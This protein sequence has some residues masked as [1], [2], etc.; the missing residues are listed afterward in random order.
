[1]TLKYFCQRSFNQGISDSYTAV[2]KT[3]S[4][5]ELSYKMPQKDDNAHSVH[6]NAS[7]RSKLAVIKKFIQ[8]PKGFYFNK[9][10]GSAYGEGYAFHQAEVSR[11]PRLVEWILKNDYLDYQNHK[12]YYDAI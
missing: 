6:F 7:I 8:D 10:I 3:S 11:N 1:M 2:R 12:A 9:K 5:R 4:N